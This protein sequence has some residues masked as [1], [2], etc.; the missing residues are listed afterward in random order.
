MT[1]GEGEG[2][3]TVDLRS[4]TGQ[5]VAM[6]NAM[7]SDEIMQGY[8]QFAQ[9]Q[10][11]TNPDQAQMFFE[12][13]MTP[14]LTTTESLR[15]RQGWGRTGGPAGALRRG[16]L[17]AEQNIVA[18][19]DI[20][21]QT[22]EEFGP[23]RVMAEIEPLLER[24]GKP[25]VQASDELKKALGGLAQ[26]MQDGTFSMDTLKQAVQS[27]Q[28]GLMIAGTLTA[29]GANSSAGVGLGLG[30]LGVGAASWGG[31]FGTPPAQ[32]GWDLPVLGDPFATVPARRGPA[33]VPQQSTR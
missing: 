11:G 25:L 30:M 20:A 1:F 13:F 24:L 16:D 27:L 17:A 2:K 14:G 9:Q 4:I 18:T 12:H 3:V 21:R 32:P 28:G 8:W 10:A 29:L 5:R 26:S 31:L 23:Q 19:R 33:L 22:A 6:E 7:Q 15:V